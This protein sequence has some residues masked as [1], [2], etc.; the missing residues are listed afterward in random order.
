MD[1]YR[2]TANDDNDVDE[3]QVSSLSR[4]SNNMMD[5]LSVSQHTTDM[6]NIRVM[7]G[8]MNGINAQWQRFDGSQPPDAM[9][10]LHIQR[11]PK[12]DENGNPRF[13]FVYN[14]T[15]WVTATY[16]TYLDRGLVAN[17]EWSIYYLIHL[18]HQTHVHFY[19]DNYW[20]TFKALL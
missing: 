1:Y 4:C 3:Q 9:L 12:R 13:F 19:H 11:H 10:E 20:F 17:D 7:N 14:G 15:V 6:I 5:R 8:F 18:D 16:Y 2:V